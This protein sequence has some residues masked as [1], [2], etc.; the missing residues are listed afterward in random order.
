[1]G[2]DI[3]SI[4]DLMEKD[5]QF[6]DFLKRKERQDRR[7]EKPRPFIQPELPVPAPTGRETEPAITLTSEQETA[8]R[9]LLSGE[10]VFLSGKAG[11]GKSYITREFIKKSKDAGK[12]ILVCAPTGIAALNVGGAT[13]H[14]TF[15]VPTEIITPGNECDNKK[16]MKVIDKADIILIDEISMCRTDLFSFIGRSI[17]SSQERTGR[18]KQVVVVGDFFQLP[19]V[20]RWEDKKHYEKL[21]GDKV[22]AFE[23]VV[24][25]KLDFKYVELN[26][27]VRQKDPDFMFALNNIR[28]GVPDLSLFREFVDDDKEAITICGTN[29]EAFTINCQRLAMLG[30]TQ[31][32][33]ADQWGICDKVPTE[34]RVKLAVGARVILLSND[35]KGRWANGTLATVTALFPKKIGIRVNN[36]NEYE[37]EYY[38]WETKEYHL[39]KR[40]DG[41]YRVDADVIGSFSQLPVKLAYAITI[42]RS[43]G[44]TYD[45]VNIHPE[46]I[47]AEGQLYVALSRCRSL[48]GIRIVGHLTEKQLKVSETVME[49]YKNARSP[50]MTTTFPKGGQEIDNPKEVVNKPR[51]SVKKTVVKKQFSTHIGN[52]TR[53]RILEIIEADPSTTSMEIAK[54]LGINRSAV[55]KHLQKL[56]ADGWLHR[57]GS[58]KSGRWEVYNA[59][60]IN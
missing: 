18:K 35:D 26:D 23:S 14:R 3:L 49:F 43:Q 34:N 45:K 30:D 33:K 54:A 16:N 36:G 57:S 22:Y 39:Q 56:T 41:S 2:N 48:D 12:N 40:Y 25:K 8:M 52:A 58:K 6:V 21:Y 27:I 31:I 4:S 17:F 60:E 19:P 50:L 47:F 13:L 55:Q 38:T 37:L 44:Q 32:Y 9:V 59:V 5:R 29:N 20:L 24:W 7:S 11:T 51:E 28:E 46:G 15:R 42:H 53:N 1:M 10:N